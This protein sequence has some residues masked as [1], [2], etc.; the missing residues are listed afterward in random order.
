MSAIIPENP[1][2]K[3]KFC[4]YAAT[5]WGLELHRTFFPGLW[6]GDGRYPYRIITPDA[7]WDP[8]LNIVE[9]DLDCYNAEVFII[10]TAKQRIKIGGRTLELENVPAGENRIPRVGS[11]DEHKRFDPL[12]RWVFNWNGLED[13][14]HRPIIHINGNLRD[15]RTY[16]L[17]LGDAPLPKPIPPPLSVALSRV[18]TQIGARNASG[19]VGVS[20]GFNKKTSR[21]YYQ[22]TW[23]ENGVRKVGK[24]HW[25]VDLDVAA[26]CN[27]AEADRADA[28]ERLGD[29]NVVL[30]NREELTKRK[31]NKFTKKTKETGKVRV[32]PSK[33]E[34]AEPTTLT[35]CPWLSEKPYATPYPNPYRVCGPNEIEM[36][37]KKCKSETILLSPH[38]WKQI[39]EFRWTLE[40]RS[41]RVPAS[42]SV[43]IKVY[44]REP[45]ADGHSVIR[46]YLTDFISKYHSSY[47]L[48]EHL[49]GNPFDFRLENLGPCLPGNTVCDPKVKSG[50]V[51]I[52]QDKDYAGRSF[53]RC[54]LHGLTGIMEHGTE[55]Y[56]NPNDPQDKHKALLTALRERYEMSLNIQREKATPLDAS[57]L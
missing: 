29:P 49:N 31:M 25:V 14:M 2:P 48:P 43:S 21:T 15:F 37:F 35:E 50:Y 17:D 7:P 32:I 47:G 16:N 26:A 4:G 56:F 30:D 5:T 28:L 24:K 53:Y 33:W 20:T 46:H 22:A 36:A 27:A 13:Q 54:K 1:P 9:I 41:T 38:S 51:G 45:L 3:P 18:Q 57:N 52:T 19:T 40:Q 8:E 42:D 55:F 11:Y 23:A 34:I 39:R 12:I 44:R 10:M 6:K